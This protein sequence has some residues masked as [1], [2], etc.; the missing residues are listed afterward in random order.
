MAVLMGLVASSGAPP[1]SGAHSDVELT[2]RNHTGVPLRGSPVRGGVPFARGVLQDCREAL[3]VTGAG[4]ELPCR[5]RPAARWYDG[6]VKWLMVDTQ[7]DLPAGEALK[8]RLSPGPAAAARQTDGRVTLRDSEDMIEAD[9][10]PTRY[11]F[12]K[13]RFGLPGAAWAD[14]DGDGRAETQVMAQPGQFVCEVEHQPPGPP[15]E[16]N[17]LRDAAR[18]TTDAAGAPRETFTA[19]PSDGY[20]AEVESANDLRAVIKLSGWLVNDKGRKLIQYVI[21]VHACA[22]RPEIEICPT[23][24]YAGRPKEDF[25][26]ALYLRFPRIADGDA[27]WALGGETRHEGRFN[28]D[29]D[30]SL[31][32]IGPE[33]FYHL[34][35]YTQDKTVYYSLLHGGKKIAGGK[36]AAGW[37]QVA[38][39]RGSAQAAV[40]NFWQM[41]PKELKAQRDALTVY[42]WPEQ[43]GKVLDFRRRYDEVENVY[44][45]DLSLWEYGGEGV[46]VTHQIVLHFGAEGGAHTTAR[47]NAPLLLQCAPQ[48]YADTLAFGPFAVADPVRYPRLEGLQA[49][50]VEWMRHNQR[51]FHWDGMIDYGDTFF[52]G[53]ET[54]SHYGYQ[55][56]KTWCSRGYVGWLNSECVMVHAL[57][58]QYLRTGDY[59][60]FLSAAEMARHS[61]DVDVCHHCAA[62]PRHVGGGH[63]HDQQHWGNGVRGYGADTQGIM[64]LYLLTGDE[65]A[66]D[67]ARER[68]MYH[69]N[70]S[71]SEDHDQV[72]GL[73]RFWEITGED[74]WRRRA[75]EI[76]AKQLKVSPDA[77]WRFVTPPHFR[78]ISGAS[79]SLQ[80]YYWAASPQ[81][82]APLREAVVRSARNLRTWDAN[83]LPL[84]V[85][86][87]AYQIEG[88]AAPPGRAHTQMLAGLLPY[89][90]MPPKGE[91]PGDYRAFLRGLAFE[92]MVETALRW[93][94][95]N[96]YGALIHNLAPLPYVIGALQKAGLDEKAV[97]S[98]KFV[99]P[100][101]PP[102]EE[103]LDAKK[104]SADGMYK[105]NKASRAYMYTLT[106][107]APC[108]RAGR[109]QL[110]LLEDGKPLQA[111]QAHEL[112]RR[113]GL[114]RF[115]HWGARGLIFSSTDN[116]DPRTNGREYRVVY[117]WPKP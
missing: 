90:R 98:M 109:S 73:Y 18:H 101:P 2:I 85:C 103:R 99:S 94:V 43:G 51:I 33:K 52:H 48:Y 15:T 86:S 46:G 81:E 69:D 104:V 87:L 38:D 93:G 27:Q 1:T 114:G 71:P 61:M 113:E 77:K 6:S 35:P 70:G 10:G 24:I 50:A 100:P 116:T 108:D 57:F 74:H 12:P 22:G 32:C 26:R 8:L 54:P 76:L 102:F 106:K 68:A 66:L 30:V 41:H 23:F 89:L 9:T 58:L 16:E 17:W 107:G 36:E 20:K 67:V 91:T 4:I 80:Y 21:R 83:Y 112:I 63:R 14:L 44:H 96:L 55:A 78:F 79:I 97:F 84:I 75:A 59:A 39:R 47:L 65:R 64:D 45:Y 82:T 49:V 13:K 11:Q 31:F 19:G 111:H 95:N 42:L 3:L 105:G 92:E 40:R 88:D 29:E 110:M 28:G 7:V 72:G 34:I 60:L 117:P 5:V 62:E 115:S 25:I 37:V 56:P 53:Y